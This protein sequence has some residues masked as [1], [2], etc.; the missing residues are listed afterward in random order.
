MNRVDR[1]LAAL[2][3]RQTGF[4]TGTGAIETVNWLGAWTL[5]S[6]E[7]RR[8]TKIFVQ[9]VLAPMATTVIFMLIFTIAL[10]R[11]R[12]DI[13]GV[14][15]IAFLAP[16]LVMMAVIQNAF[17]NPSFS[18]LIAKTMGSIVDTLM[19]PL[20]PHE[21]VL[22]YALGGATRGLAVGAASAIALSFLAPLEPVQIGVVLYFAFGAALMM[23]LM[24][25]IAGIWAERMDSLG[26]ITSFVI[27]P[28]SFLS[29]TFYSI[30]SLPVF[31][32]TLDRFNPL[33]Y[34]I[35]G[36]RSGFIGHADAPFWLAAT[37][38]AGT[39]VVLWFMAYRMVAT[40]YH[41]KS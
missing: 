39:I 31:F 14:H 4:N 29:G 18:I 21:L 28:L 6:R 11:V 22:G 16:G 40:G 17:A 37:V 38:V 32:R 26:I 30:H 35:D 34:L 41:L 3:E 25:V 24:G 7:V 2:P 20:T 5:Y 23:A 15:F 12:G 27:M 1:P 10:G 19:P 36:F 8:F 33:F 13:A 9:T